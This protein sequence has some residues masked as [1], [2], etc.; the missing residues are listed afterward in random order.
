MILAKRVLIQLIEL[1]VATRTSV[2]IYFAAKVC[3]MRAVD[4]LDHQF[5]QITSL[6]YLAQLV[7]VA[8]QPLFSWG[9]P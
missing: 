7:L 4:Y 6:S 5:C 9:H 8:A 2:S 3:E 1:L